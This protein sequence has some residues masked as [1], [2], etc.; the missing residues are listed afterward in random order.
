[1]HGAR[2]T[3]PSAPPHSCARLAD[4]FIC[5]LTDTYL[6]RPNCLK[7]F[8]AAAR[9]N[10]L[11]VP[12]LLPGYIHGRYDGEQGG[13]HAALGVPSGRTPWPPSTS[14]EPLVASTLSGRAGAKDA[15]G[16]LFV[17]MRTNALRERNFNQIVN[18]I[19]TA[20]RRQRAL[21]GLRGAIA[22]TAA[23]LRDREPST[24]SEPSPRL[25]LLA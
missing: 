17:D 22:D 14:L 24:A 10:K 20:V 9:A 6:S 2:L 11:I 25:D 4:V 15:A 19:D 16:V 23:S 1:M 18:Q 13:G 3:P 8:A 7:E 21:K 12:L 5:C